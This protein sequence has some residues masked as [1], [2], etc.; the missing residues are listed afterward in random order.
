M[1]LPTSRAPLLVVAL[2]AAS[3]REPAKVPAPAPRADTRA[4]EGSGD[5]FDPKHRFACSPLGEVGCQ[6]I[7]PV[8]SAAD[9][10][11]SEAAIPWGGHQA[12]RARIASLRQA[13]RS[14]RI[15]ALIFRAD[16]AG[17]YV[18]GWLK[19]KREEGLE[20]RVIVDALSNLDWQT[21]WMYFDLKR[22]GIEVEG[23]EALY[24]Q[25][26][27]AEVKAGDPLRANKRFHDK[28]WVVDGE[29]PARALAIVGGMNIA[30]E[31][32]ELAAGPSGNWRDQDIVLRGPIVSDVRATFDRN[33][34][35]FKSLKS[36][37][38]GLANPDN[39]WKLT[40]ATLKRVRQ[41]S[42]ATWLRKAVTA[43]VAIE[44]GQEPTLDFAPFTGRFVQSRPRLEELFIKQ[45]Y[46]D[47]IGRAKKRIGIANAYVIPSRE[48]IE[49]LK[50]A[51][52]RG[53]R[54]S[55]LTNSPKTNDIQSVAV[56]SRHIYSLMLEPALGDA[57]A[58]HEWLGPGTL[59]AK[60][61][62]FDDEEAIIGS[63]NLDP[64]SERLN[65]ETVLAIRDRRL[66]GQLGKQLFERD[67]K[68]SV[69]IA[70]D[71]AA[72]Y[73]APEG[74]EGQF[75]LLFLSPLKGWL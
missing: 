5:I 7:L 9:R 61:A 43:Q 58:I 33:Y 29:D 53:V 38:P 22:H 31:Y 2:L 35:F 18:A 10:P 60:L 28:M 39:A 54:V 67:L 26:A 1:S 27:T 42:S 16:E 51:A 30:N 74:I 25:W 48:L 62:V 73:H 71:E 47:L 32:F 70:A 37:L 23:Y 64:R 55:I 56:I 13:K 75:K 65:S 49:A 21:Q 52:R 68:N 59:H 66:A 45:V 57:L 17:L 19:K 20:V 8:R 3:C 40:G 24:L 46:L 4:P 44:G 14:I 15:Q 72:R 12:F 34:D 41:V 63:Y 50:A 36:G 69:R 11:A 6:G